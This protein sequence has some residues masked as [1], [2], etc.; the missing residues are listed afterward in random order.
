M[1]RIE[2]ARVRQVARLAGLALTGPEVD[3]LAEELGEI[4]E[5]AADLPEIDSEEGSGDGPDS[6]A[7]ADLRAD[8]PGSDPLS[9]G[10]GELTRG[11]RDGF[12]LVPR[13]SVW[14]R[15]RS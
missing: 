14:R 1:T 8:V 9:F 2:E 10:P 6:D 3:R 15:E 12:F 11:W 5:R 13:L 7:S 4:L